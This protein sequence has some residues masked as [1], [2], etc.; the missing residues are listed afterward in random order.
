MKTAR[1]LLWILANRCYINHLDWRKAD[2]ITLDLDS[3][4]E[5][6]KEVLE[7]LQTMGQ[8]IANDPNAA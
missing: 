2:V 3:R 6:D 5:S 7:D 8:L 1:E 4:Q